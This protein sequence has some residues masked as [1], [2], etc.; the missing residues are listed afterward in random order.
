MKKKRLIS[1]TINIYPGSILKNDGTKL[2]VIYLRGD[3]LDAYTL[4][5]LYKT[6]QLQKY[7][8]TSLKRFVNGN[9]YYAYGWWAPKDK[10][11]LDVLYQ[12]KIKPCLDFIVNIEDTGN[13]VGKGDRKDKVLEILDELIA[14]FDPEN[15]PIFGGDA[16]IQELN[17]KLKKFKLE[18][19]TAVSEQEFKTKM[20]KVL[21]LNRIEGH[22]FS[23][24]NALLLYLQ[25]PT[26]KLVKS[27][28]NWY[29][30]N[31]WVS[32]RSHPIYLYTPNSKG[33]TPQQQVEV[34]ETY[35][36][37]LGVK[38]VK[39]LTPGQKEELRVL[40]RGYALRDGVS[41]CYVSPYY[42]IRF[43][44]PIDGKEDLAAVYV[45]KPEKPNWYDTSTET[46]KELELF[47]K[48]A[49]QMAEDANLKINYKTSAELGGARGEATSLGTINLLKDTG[50][51]KNLAST[52]CHE[53][54]H[55]VMHL[56]FV[57]N[58]KDDYITK[59]WKKYCKGTDKG[60]GFIEQQAEICAWITLKFFGIDV[61][62][63]AVTYAKCWGM[64][65]PKDSF[66]VFD[67][68][69]ALANEMAEKIKHNIYI[70][71]KEEE[72]EIQ[73]D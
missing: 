56:H 65:T 5:N 35:L 1:E 59:V 44:S 51:V 42:D 55:Q 39:E 64:M 14:T 73:E 68:V 28:S 47:I 31:R 66:T 27:V 18:L 6:N 34:E 10:E 52:I 50:Y 71:K 49:I 3:D 37:S 61:T 15:N 17:V 26:A 58:Q 13:G 72:N 38:D 46:S 63:S 70:L 12:E 20:T 54:A 40:Q 62:Q 69:A 45:D 30:L 8:V 23:V 36:K 43:T 67:S 19:A 57:E 41:K 7:G 21:D 11:K 32:D 53:Y 2:N 25:D 22:Q 24:K 60:R 33:L 4:Y 29:Q 9:W 16:Y 48:A